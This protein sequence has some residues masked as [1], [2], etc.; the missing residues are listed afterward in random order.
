[1][2]ISE[3]DVGIR[4]NLSLF[5]VQLSFVIEHG[6]RGIRTPGTVSR[7]T[8]F[9]TAALNHSAIPPLD[10]IADNLYENTPSNNTSSRVSRRN[11][12]GKVRNPNDEKSD[13]RDI[14]PVLYRADC[15]CDFRTHRRVRSDHRASF[16]TTRPNRSSFFTPFISGADPSGAVCRPPDHD[17]ICAWRIWPSFGSA[18]I[19]TVR[20]RV[21]KVHAVESPARNSL[22]TRQKL[23]GI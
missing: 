16:A 18:G 17:R 15:C 1:M 22:T 10:R 9:K 11:H 4:G 21:E 2:A 3:N 5:N 12:N 13:E 7:P 19:D 6:G 20:R 8:V 23:P 14:P